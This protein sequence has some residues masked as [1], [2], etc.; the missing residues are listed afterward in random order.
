M[1][2]GRPPK[3]KLKEGSQHKAEAGDDFEYLNEESDQS[4]GDDD[5]DLSD[6]ESMRRAAKR[7]HQRGS[8]VK[9]SGRSKKSGTPT[10]IMTPTPALDNDSDYDEIGETKVDRGG[11]LLGGR[12]YK[13]P[14]FAL[15]ER[16]NMLF[17]FS[18]DPAAL[19]GFRDS[20]VFLKKNPKL[21]KVHVTDD[22]KGY[23]VQQN[24]LRSTFRTREVS[25]VTARSVYKQFGHRVLRKGRR[26]RDDYYYTGE[27][28]GDL[29]DEQSE[30]EQKDD[31]AWSPFVLSGRNNLTSRRLV[32][33]VVAPATN[34]LNYMHHAAL[35]IR[36]FNTQL[37]DYRRDNPTF[38]DIHTNVMQLPAS[39]Q[40]VRL[41]YE[42]K[43]IDERSAK[44]APT[45][46][47]KSESQDSTS[48]APA[49]PAGGDPSS[50]AVAGS[51]ATQD[52][53]QAKAESSADQSQRP[54]ASGASHPG[55]APQ[56]RTY[57]TQLPQ[58]KQQQQ[59]Q[60]APQT[61]QQA[62]AQAQSQLQQPQLQQ[63]PPQA[64]TMM[65]RAPPQMANNPLFYQQM[66]A[67]GQ[68]QRPPMGF[69][70][71]QQMMMQQGQGQ[72]MNPAYTTSMSGIN[73]YQFM[74]P[75]TM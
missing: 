12:Q 56:Q 13:V 49:E 26:G 45:T 18:K 61:P 37:C 43:K 71:Q 73:P 40:P 11:N 39:K 33:K 1:K 24:L 25:V 34:E 69:S 27:D 51:S 66:A 65:N 19:L 4:F 10:A 20:F 67:M 74:N 53:Q 32:G 5:V 15:P 57:P 58:Q 41:L 50:S 60:Q 9:D 55:A 75:G 62:Q 29:G 48:A 14:T 30:E 52:S 22:E 63:Q 42:P 54:Q 23:L 6:S 35:S 68:Q 7:R 44:A 72:G 3:R 36:N 46:E 8:S 16:G 38:F 28:E 2:K 21:V 59:Q 70:P 47:N 64:Q 17:M 31:K